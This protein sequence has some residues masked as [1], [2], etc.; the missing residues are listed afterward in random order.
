MSDATSSSECGSLCEGHGDSVKIV[1]ARQPNLFFST[2]VSRYI[3]EADIVLVSVNTPTKSKGMG[4]GSATDMTAFEAVTGM[5]ARHA[6]PGA[7][8]VE[9]STVPCRTAELVKETVSSGLNAQ[10]IQYAN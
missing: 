2:E 4:A 9:K 7:I 8:I 1:P 5:V 10:H 6:R 3:S